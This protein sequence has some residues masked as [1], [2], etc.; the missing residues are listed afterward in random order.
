MSLLLNGQKT[1]TLAGTVMSCIEVYT[2]EAY[3]LP[4][5]IT[6]N[7]GNPVNCSGWTIA[8][9][10]KFYTVSNITYNST[11]TEIIVGDLTLVSPQPNPSGYST[12]TSAFT[13]PAS[14]VGYV[15]V[16]ETLTGSPTLTV[17]LTNSTANSSLAIL[18]LTITRTDLLSTR[19]NIS[20][21]PIG[22]IVRYQ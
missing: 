9:S 21:E 1:L 7:V 19:Q 16:P 13:T 8:V 22:I 17:G 11:N 20:R 5:T 6:D 4:F 14:G 2:G 18:T 12:L 10:A 15:Y 3:T